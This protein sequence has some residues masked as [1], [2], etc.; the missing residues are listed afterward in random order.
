[1]V[2]SLSLLEVFKWVLREHGESQAL[3]ASAVMQQGQV[4]ALDAALALSAAKLG[5]KHQLPLAD[6][7]M[8]GC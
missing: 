7:V 1:V 5:L 6:S 3:Q 4:V 8:L 2:P